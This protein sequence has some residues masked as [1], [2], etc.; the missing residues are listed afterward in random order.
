MEEQVLSFYAHKY[1][2]HTL[3]PNDEDF[4]DE[5]PSAL[6]DALVLHRFE[7]TI[8]KVP[9]LVGVREDVVRAHPHCWYPCIWW[10]EIRMR[11]WNDAQVVALCARFKI[12]PIMPGDPLMIQ[13]TMY[14]RELLI[15]ARG[16][17]FT[18]HEGFETEH[19]VGAFFG[20][21]VQR[22]KAFASELQLR[23]GTGSRCGCY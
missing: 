17:V 11:T 3:F 1:S 5:L 13:G 16:V 2:T 10:P 7:E 4:L 15:V 6:H 23:A 9:F 12:A 20:G 18:V 19:N 8:Q 21:T 22:L 14:R